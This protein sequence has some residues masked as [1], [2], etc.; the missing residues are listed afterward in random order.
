MV[1]RGDSVDILYASE[2]LTIVARGRALDSGAPGDVVRVL[3]VDS[4]RTIEGVVDSPGLVRIEIGL[5]LAS[6]G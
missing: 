6:A 1:G 3:N 2:A 4:N 5:R